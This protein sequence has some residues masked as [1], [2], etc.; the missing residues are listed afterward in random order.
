MTTR[1]EKLRTAQA[2]YEKRIPANRKVHYYTP[3]CGFNIATPKP[4]SDEPVYDSFAV[5]CGCGEFYFRVVKHDGTV[6]TRLNTENHT[7]TMT[8]A[9]R[10]G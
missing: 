2:E 6:K 8:E 9:E 1:L 3:C 7:D 4:T 10:N 5:C